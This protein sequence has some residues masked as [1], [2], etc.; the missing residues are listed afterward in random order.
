MT[1]YRIIDLETFPRRAHMEYFLSLSF[2]FVE[3]TAD[4]DVTELREFCR[5]VDCSFYL[6]FLHIAALSAEAVP[7]LRQR[8]H[9]LSPE[10][11]ADPL[12]AGAPK[13]GPLAGVELREYAETPS[14]HTE[15]TDDGIYCYCTLYHH[16]PWEEYISYAAERQKKA[17][18][19][20]SLEEDDDVEAFCFPTCVPW[21]RFTS[22]VHPMRDVLDSNPRICWGKFSEDFRGRL[23]M[24]L[25]LMVNHALVDGMQIGRF[26]ENIEKNIAALVEGRLQY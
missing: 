6:A 20:A 13:E 4:I 18:E 22:S 9:V 24:P 26:F 15:S 8:L 3:F 1:D 16:M 23:T 12:H 7:E 14:S 17:R 10:E 19:K 25:T 2:P 5:R 21:I 11:L